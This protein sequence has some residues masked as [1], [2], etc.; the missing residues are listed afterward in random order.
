MLFT[1][2]VHSLVSYQTN[3]MGIDVSKQIE[4]LSY[5]DD[6]SSKDFENEFSS[7]LSIE[8]HKTP[9]IEEQRF[10]DNNIHLV[11]FN[12]L[13]KLNNDYQL[14]ANFYYVNDF[15]HQSS[16]AS[17]QLFQPTDTI[18][19]SETYSNKYFDNYMNG[20]FTI[21]KNTNKNYFNNKTKIKASW[22]SLQADVVRNNQED[23]NQSNSMP[24]TSISNEFV[25]YYE[26]GK[27]LLKINSSVDY[28]SGNQSLQVMPGP[29]EIIINQ[30]DKYKL[31]N[32]LVNSRRF[33]TNNY[34]SITYG[35][36]RWKISPNLGFEIQ[37][38]VFDSEIEKENNDLTENAGKLFNNDL[39]AHQVKVY[40]KT[41]IEYRSKKWTVITS[42]PLSWYSVF[43][44][45]K[46]LKEGQSL[47]RF[48]AD[49]NI[50]AVFEWNSDWKMTSY[51]SYSNRIENINQ[52]RYAY[53]LRNYREISKNSAPVSESQNI[54]FRQSIQ[55]RNAVNAFFNTLTYSYFVRNRNIIYDKIVQQDG[56]ALVQ[57][58][59]L[60][61]TAYIH[62]L[63]LNSS[64][65]VSK[66]RSTFRLNLLFNHQRAP[67]LL[68][69]E[70]FETKNILYLFSPGLNLKIFVRLNLD[71]SLEIQ[72]TDIFIENEKKNTI[73]TFKQKGK[74]LF[75]PT[76][77]Q[78]IYL[79]LEHYNID[80]QN[81]FFVDLN[82]QFSIPNT[83]WEIKLSWNNILNNRS[84]RNLSANSYNVTESVFLLRP[85]QFMVSVRLDLN[86]LFLH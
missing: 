23:I 82:Y 68:N 26:I 52:I 16:E 54:V 25:S 61:N 24:F 22:N 62:S 78:M 65:Y 69:R 7:I 12:T 32:Q 31:A 27:R 4:K 73:T 39:L 80:A 5:N 2:K 15:R 86:A 6:L 17:T 40:G 64:K 1:K 55:Y 20:V 43:L 14:R 46:V 41:N 35:L 45:D 44:E 81:D 58:N 74:L 47:I 21:F 51:L 71:Y 70:L 84:Y 56:T 59:F 57:A 8:N 13:I 9:Q 63:H 37:H 67:S 72:Q 36:K 60:P 76:N 49:P 42:I 3:N 10:L 33:Y 29:F 85:S 50:K 34:A 66:L 75:L 48:Y 83:L 53:I 38:Y 19:Y 28:F 11:N 18:K 77:E 30:G 79:L